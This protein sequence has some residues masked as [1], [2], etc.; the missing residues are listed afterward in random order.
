MRQPCPADGMVPHFLGLWIKK[1]YLNKKIMGNKHSKKALASLSTYEG[2]TEQHDSYKQF[3]KVKMCLKY[4]THLSDKALLSLIERIVDDSKDINDIISYIYS[5][6]A[7]QIASYQ[8]ASSEQA[9]F[10]NEKI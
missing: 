3:L 9:H 8:T 1:K 5:T 4:G 10:S 6:S 7:V 2:N